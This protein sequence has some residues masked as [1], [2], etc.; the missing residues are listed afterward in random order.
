M[1]APEA[2]VIQQAHEPP[3]PHMNVEQMES[4]CLYCGSAFSTTGWSTLVTCTGVLSAYR[5]DVGSIA[6]ISPYKAQVSALKEE[7]RRML[8]G[9]AAL[10]AANI[11]FGTVDGFQ[12]GGKGASGHIFLAYTSTAELT[13]P[14]SPCSSREHT[15]VKQSIA[16]SLLCVVLLQGREADIVVFSCVRAQPEAVAAAAASFADTLSPGPSNAAAAASR[17][18]AAGAPRVGFL[19]DVRRMNVGLTR[20]RRAV[21]VV[22]HADTLAASSAWRPLLQEAR[23]RGVLLEAR[24]PFNRLLSASDRQ[25]RG[26][27]WTPTAAAVAGEGETSAVQQHHHDV[28]AV[29]DD[30]SRADTSNTMTAEVAAGKPAVEPQIPPLSRKY[31][32]KAAAGA[33]ESESQAVAAAAIA[34]SSGSGLAGKRSSRIPPPAADA[35][36]VGTG[37]R[38]T[39]QQPSRQAAGPSLETAPNVA[40]AAKSS[41]VGPS[42]AAAAQQ[43]SADRPGDH[44]RHRNATAARAQAARQQCLQEQQQEQAAQQLRHQ[45]QRHQ[46]HGKLKGPVSKACVKTPVQAPAAARQHDG[47]GNDIIPA[48][49]GANVSNSHAMK[50]APASTSGLRKM[51]FAQNSAARKPAAPKGTVGGDRKQTQPRSGGNQDRLKEALLRRIEEQQKLQ[52]K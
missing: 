38:K 26:S 48:V 35:T 31:E 23:S 18:P 44:S 25:L 30:R 33:A 40:A 47:S 42:N 7:F 11:E 32:A 8:G 2:R 36:A 45:Q 50:S 19:A 41:P 14:C 4:C 24:A 5:D 3:H 6:V 1:I 27:Y 39:P 43:A 15:V 10:T 51:V 52:K 28:A 13:L 37:T 16:Q 49:A 12:V 34:H 17:A 21:W 29:T 9:D 20:G 22:G 46:Q